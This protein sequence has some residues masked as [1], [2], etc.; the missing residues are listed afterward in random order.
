MHKF[1]TDFEH[2]KKKVIVSNRI[3]CGENRIVYEE[4]RIVCEENDCVLIQYQ[5]FG[6]FQ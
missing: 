1:K 3:F 2:I 4:N 5:L 6:H